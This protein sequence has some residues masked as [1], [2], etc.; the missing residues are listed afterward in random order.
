MK[1]VTA[2]IGLDGHFRGIKF[3][4]RVL[5]DAGAEVVYLGFHNSPEQVA[6]V[7][8]DEDAQLLALSFLSPDYMTHVRLLRELLVR[9]GASDVRIIIGGLIDPADGA[10]L[11]TLGVDRIFGPETKATQITDYLLEQ[12]GDDLAA[13]P[14]GR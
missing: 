7:V 2:K 4:T 3:V 6:R 11:E 1:A 9:E 8:V 13:K 12:F 14:A 10:E 5:R